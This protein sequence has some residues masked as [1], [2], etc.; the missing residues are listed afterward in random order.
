MGRG[1][2]RPATSAICPRKWRCS[3]QRSR[4]TSRALQQERRCRD[5]I[6]G[7]QGRRRPRDD[8]APAGRLPNTA[9]AARRLHSRPGS[10]SASAWPGRC[11]AIP[12]WSLWTSRTPISTARARPRLTRAIEGDRRTW[13]HRHRDRPSAERARRR[14]SSR[15]RTGGANDGVRCQAR[16]LGSNESARGR[17]SCASVG[18]P[19]E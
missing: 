9:R 6:R 3:M 16:N 15:R 8:R 11:T 19:R 13:R 4:R 14:G 5:V 2:A 10:A 7:R 17:G 18:R 12:S 1:G